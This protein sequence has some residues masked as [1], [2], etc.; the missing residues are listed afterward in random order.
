[1][2]VRSTVRDHSVG[3]RRGARRRAVRVRGPDRGRRPRRTAQPLGWPSNRAVVDIAATPSG[4]GYWL[5]A[6]RRRHLRLRR[7]PLPR[8]HRRP[9]TSTNPSSAS[10]PHPPATATGSPPPTAAS[11]PSATPAST[12]PP[13]PSTSTNPSSASPPHP[14]ATATGSPPPTAASSPSATPASTAPPAAIRLNQPIVGIAATPTGNGYWLAASD[15]GIF[16]FGDARFHGSTGGMRLSAPITGLAARA[17]RR[18]LARRR[19][20]RDLRVRRRAVP[21]IRERGAAATRRRRRRRRRPAATGSRPEYGAVHTATEN[22]RF[23]VD[24]NSVPADRESSSGD[25]AGRTG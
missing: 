13:A 21:R 20:R 11:S 9:S 14:P 22:G 15:G 24:P 5:V 17:A 18:I 4:N 8:L 6:V 25:G 19:G 2:D 16:A 1:M 3:E 10:P 12:A 7:R 23:V